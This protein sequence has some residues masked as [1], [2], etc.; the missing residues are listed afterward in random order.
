M[1]P[2]PEIITAGE[3][4]KFAAPVADVRA[5]DLLK[6][7]WFVHAARSL[8][9]ACHRGEQ[10]FKSGSLGLQCKSPSLGRVTDNLHSRLRKLLATA[11][12]AELGPGPRSGVR[13]LAE[14]KRELESILGN[15]DL[16]E[17]SRDLIRSLVLL[18]HDHLDASHTI[19]QSIDNSDGSLLHAIMHRRE[20]DYW[21]SKY[22]WRRVGKH[23]CFGEFGKGVSALLD[24][25]NDRDLLSKLVPRGEWDPFAFVDLCEAAASKVK[26]SEQVQQLREIQR[27]ETEVALEYFLH[28]A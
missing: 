4:R 5:A 11:E 20:P 22:W 21:N 26:A 15:G 27:I 19:S 6:R 13:S 23:P 24:S 7:L 2:Q 16:P 9:S 10:T 25:R 17:T 1:T 18:W 12:T 14:L 3:I 8:P 28:G